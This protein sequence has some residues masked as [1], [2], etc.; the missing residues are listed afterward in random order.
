MGPV[1]QAHN[2]AGKISTLTQKQLLPLLVG[3]A[4]GLGPGCQR[5]ASTE[6]TKDVP[7]GRRLCRLE[8]NLEVSDK[9]CYCMV[10]VL[11]EPSLVAQPGT[12]WLA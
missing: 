8:L 10:E 9:C 3:M 2:C 12:E 5:P 1:L 6:L 7:L 4:F 11:P